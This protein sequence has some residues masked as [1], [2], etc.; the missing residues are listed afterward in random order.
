M[1]VLVI[2]I[3]QPTYV[4]VLVILTVIVIHWCAGELLAANIN[5]P[6]YV[7]VLLVILTV[8]VIHWRA[9]EL[10][11]ANVVI[12]KSHVVVAAAS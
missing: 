10:L 3:S 8:I 5:Q 12:C 11:A 9:G 7:T 2:L 4:T 1:T 6:T